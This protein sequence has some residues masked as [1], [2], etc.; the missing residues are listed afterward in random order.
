MNEIFG[1]NASGTP[2]ILIIKFE[3]IFIVLNRDERYDEH[4]GK[5]CTRTG[6][7]ISDSI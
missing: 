3:K 5:A 2:W 1:G 4:Y 6:T 7:V